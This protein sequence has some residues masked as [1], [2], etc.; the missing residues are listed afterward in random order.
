MKTLCFLIIVK[1]TVS[2]ISNGH[3]CKN[4]NCP[5]HNCFLIYNVDDIF[6]KCLILIT[7]VSC[8]LLSSVE[9]PEKKIFTVGH[10]FSKA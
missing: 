2:E 1:G 7:P 5:V 6:V 10:F 8:L 3:P 9:K 4:H